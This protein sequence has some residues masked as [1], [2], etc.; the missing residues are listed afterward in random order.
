MLTVETCDRKAKEKILKI[1]RRL[2]V[3]SGVRSAASRKKSVEVFGRALSPADIVKRIVQDI[4]SKGDKALFYYTRKLDGANLNSRT[5]KATTSEIESA[6][7]KLSKRFFKALREACSNIRAFQSHIKNKE[8][9]PLKR[10]EA[11]LALRY[12]PLSRVGVY[13]PGGTAP[14][15]SSVLMNAIPAQVAGVEEIA[16]AAPPS[17]EGKIAPEILA[18]CGELRL[19]EIYK[20]GGAQAVAA[21]AFGTKSVRPVDKIAGA[22]NIFVM[23]AKKEVFGQVDIDMFAG[24]SEILIIADASARAEYVAADMLSQAEHNPGSS[25]LITTSKSLA[26]GVEKEIKTQVKRLSRSK[27]AKACLD[28]YGAVIITKSLSEAVR[29]ADEL[30]PEHL[31]IMVRNPRKVL[32]GIRNAGAILVGPHTPVAVGDYL[33]GPSHTL[34]TSGTAR[35]FSG[36]S[37]NDFLKKTS[38]IRFDEKGLLKNSDSIIELARSEGLDGHAGAVEI[39]RKRT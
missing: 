15:F 31:E 18:A 38:I 24:P 16:V 20:M 34:P 8:P 10:K 17:R 33:A 13:V 12:R 21:L 36:L 5:I 2:A 32:D 26:R 7:K 19:T 6:R 29:W 3:S 14:L 4:K 9:G 30:A 25:I 27:Q 22:G 35:F 1:K 28:A 11:T 37:V 39:R 23:L